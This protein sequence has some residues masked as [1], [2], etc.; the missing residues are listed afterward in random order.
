[1]GEKLET[2][3]GVLDKVVEMLHAFPRGD[4]ALNPREIAE[5]TGLP[6]P[7]IYRLLGALVEHGFLEKR[8]SGYRLGLALLHLGTRVSEG[9]ELR[10]QTLPYLEWL[11]EQTGENAELHVRQ[12]ET[13]VPI[14][15]VR[16]PHN[17]RPFVEIGSPLPLHLGASGKVLLAWLPE[18]ERESLAAAS[19]TRFSEGTLDM[20]TL[21]EQLDRIKARGWAASDGERSQGVAA[22]AAPVFDA[23]GGVAGA[24]LVSAPSV[25]LSSK[26]CRK[27]APLVKEA[28]ARASSDLGYAKTPSPAK[29]NPA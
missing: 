23:G 16:S 28:A 24:I 14:E 10:R 29:R 4:V 8:G 12:G 2:G 19:A 5:R 1:M 27:L 20:R 18:N 3:V 13:R 11:N 6:L 9:I 15:L 26:R 25:R 21:R 17:L 22:L 7:T